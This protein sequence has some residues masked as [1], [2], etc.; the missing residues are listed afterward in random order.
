MERKVW[1][2]QRGNQKPSV[3]WQA[4]QCR[5][6]FLKFLLAIFH[7]HQHMEFTFHNSYVF[8]EK[9]SGQSSAPDTKS[10]SN[11]VIATKILRS[12]SWTGWLLWNI[13]I[14][15]DNG[16]YPFYTF[17]FPLSQTRLYQT[18]PYA[19]QVSYKKQELLTL[20]K[21]LDSS[22]FF[23]GNRVVHLFSFLWC[24]V[25]FLFCSSSSCI[26]CA[27]VSSVSGLSILVCTFSYC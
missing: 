9:F 25:V 18:W 13:H 12:S 7:Q 26:L 16:S 20:C 23:G 15:N 22:P 6:Q 5:G 21:H 1:R 27:H 8:L 14:S 10:S 3:E 11:K 17:F 24:V 4:I 19:L 2:Y